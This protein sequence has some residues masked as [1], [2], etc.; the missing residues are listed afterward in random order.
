MQLFR[1][2]KTGQRGD[3]FSRIAEMSDK[4]PLFTKFDLYNW[5]CITPIFFKLAGIKER[6]RMCVRMKNLICA[7]YGN[8]PN[9]RGQRLNIQIAI[10]QNRK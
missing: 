1:R 10:T 4:R 3:S 8:C 7:L 6:Q 5:K 2:S 9:K